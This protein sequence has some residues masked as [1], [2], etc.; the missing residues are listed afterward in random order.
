[1]LR[2]IL[3]NSLIILLLLCATA[4]SIRYVI[5]LFEPDL[6]IKNAIHQ[7]ELHCNHSAGEAQYI[8]P[9]V[10]NIE[11]KCKDRKYK[12]WINNDT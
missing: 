12:S 11:F 3:E 5:W 8:K 2:K 7:I 1:M 4:S 10:R 9:G 6:N